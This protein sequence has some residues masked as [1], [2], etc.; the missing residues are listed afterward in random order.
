MNNR[1][2]AAAIWDVLC[3]ARC[4]TELELAGV[5]QW[6]DDPSPNTK[7][8]T[9]DAYENAVIAEHVA[10]RQAECKHG[11]TMAIQRTHPYDEPAH[12]VCQRCDKKLPL[13]ADTCVRSL[14]DVQQWTNAWGFPVRE[15]P[16][17]AMYQ[18]GLMGVGLGH[19]DRIA[20][21]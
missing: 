16:Q 19:S 3:M 13:P 15:H 9:L 17:Y 4:C 11:F 2:K 7:I 21:P 14:S 8:L 20:F 12:M 1:K 5:K 18:S 6:L 10:K